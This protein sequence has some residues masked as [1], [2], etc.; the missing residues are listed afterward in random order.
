VAC[1]EPRLAHGEE[2]GWQPDLSRTDSAL[3]D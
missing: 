3:A 1:D 2:T